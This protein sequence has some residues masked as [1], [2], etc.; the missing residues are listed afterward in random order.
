MAMRSMK[1]APSLAFPALALALV[2]CE[3]LTPSSPGDLDLGDDS[4]AVPTGDP[5]APGN[6]GGDGASSSS[7]YKN[8]LN[9]GVSDT[10]SPLCSGELASSTF[11]YGLCVCGDLSMAGHLKTSSFRSSNPD[12]PDG[13]GGGV[14]INGRYSAS[15]GA[16]IG[17]AL[18]VGGKVSPAGSYLVRGELRVGQGIASAGSLHVEGDA[19][20]DGSLNAI[21]LEVEG[22]LHTTSPLGSMTFIDA[23]ATEVSS[24]EIAP[25]CGCEDTL[26]VAGLVAQAA[27]ANDNA[28]AGIAAGVLDGLAGAAELTL[29][30]GRYY[31]SAIRA[32]GAVVF[33]L[34]GP[35][36]IYVDGDISGA[37]RVE[38]VL[39]T[40]TASLDLF[41][42]GSIRHAGQL[43]LGSATAPAR[44]RTYMGGDGNFSLAGSATLGGALYAPNAHL[45]AAGELQLNGAVLVGALSDA[46]RINVRYDADLVDAQEG[47]EIVDEAVSGDD[48]DGTGEGDVGLPGAG[49]DDGSADG[50]GDNGDG[51]APGNPGLQGDTCVSFEDCASP[52]LCIEGMCLFVGG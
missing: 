33:R 34:S 28:A 42:A 51:G 31:L 52:L 49:D 50:N 7:G 21:G 43:E 20:V 45:S 23:G 14:G 22:T 18:V 10:G 36:A 46:G 24:F 12:A 41:V 15:G 19:Y 1:L 29:P 8:A 9:V 5:R 35:T 16:D 40:E 37:G 11:R 2:A 17:G 6:P 25:P 38:A 4:S 48:G 13:D 39:E 26:D 32:A 47:C 30:A 44:V 3:P 27:S